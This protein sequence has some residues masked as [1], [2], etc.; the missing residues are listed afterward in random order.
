MEHAH[1]ISSSSDEDMNEYRITEDLDTSFHDATF[2]RSELN[3]EAKDI[4]ISPIK[5][6]SS[7]DKLSYGKNKLKRM[8]SEMQE[9][10]AHAFDIPEQELKIDDENNNYSK[11][12]D[13]DRLVDLIQEK[14][15]V[16]SR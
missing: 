5:I 11:C 2:D 6:V 16:L 13:L 7:R 8:K 3:Y 12:N 10:L 14:T 4:G 15:A 1:K 9:R